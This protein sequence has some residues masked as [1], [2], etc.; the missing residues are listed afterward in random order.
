MP[1]GKDPLGCMVAAVR[2]EISSDLL[3]VQDDLDD[4]TA[5]A[6]V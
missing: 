5:D 4:H 1:N 3:A 2:P 6:G